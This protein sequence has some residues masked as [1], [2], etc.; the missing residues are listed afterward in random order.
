MA[1]FVCLPELAFSKIQNGSVL[2]CY[3]SRI[4]VDLISKA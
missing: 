1:D 4:I 3:L 2:V